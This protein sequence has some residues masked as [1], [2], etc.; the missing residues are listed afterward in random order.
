MRDFSLARG[1]RAASLASTLLLAGAAAQD[2]PKPAPSP[3]AGLD[4]TEPFF[5]GATYDQ[6]VPTPSSV[7][8]FDVGSKPATP[9]QIEAVLKAL[10][11]R[12]PRCR[13]FAYG[14]THEGR[15]LYYLVIASEANIRRLDALKAD[16]AK[17]ADPR[18]VTRAEGDHLA[19][20]LPALAWMAYVIHGDEMSSSDAALAVAHH[21]AAGTGADVKALLDNVVIAI[22]P[23]MNPDGRDRFLA[24][25][26]QNR[27]AQPGVDDQTLLHTGFWPD[28]RANHYLFDLNRDWVFVTQPESRGRVRA[29]GEWN[30]HFLIEGHEMGAQS[31]FFFNPPREAL[32]PQF[33][34][35]EQKWEARFGAD[36]AAAFDA[37][38]WRYFNGEN[39]DNW[40]PGFT[41]SWAPLR[42]AIG[43]LY[44]QA[45]IA[46]DAVRHANTQLE[47]YRES[48]HH[49]LVSTMANL[50]FLAQHRPE[51]LADFV[52]EKR[53]VVGPDATFPARTWALLPTPNAARLRRLLDLFEVQGIEVRTA[54]KSFRAAGRDRLGRAVADREFPAGTLLVA[55]RQPLGRLV[56]AAL[57]FDP[58]MTT[59]FLTEE[60][61]E[62]LRSNP[63]RVYDTTG[64][65][66]PMLYDVEAFELAGD[67]PGKLLAPAPAP[68]PLTNA[69][70]PVA[71]ILDG[72]DDASVIAAGRLMER[73]V[74]VR[75]ADRPAQFDGRDFPRGSVVVARKDNPSFAGDL[76]ATVREVCAELQ[77]TAA[78]VRSGNGPGESFDLGG[79]HF[80]L[81]QPPRIALVGREPIRS[82]GYGEVWHLV[83]HV[84]G[85]RA[86]YVDFRT[87]RSADLRRYNVLVIP[88]GAATALADRLDSLKAWVQGGGTL[89][90]IG[91]SA[92][93]LAKDQ[94]GLGRTRQLSDVLARFDDYRQAIVREWEARH[95]T[96]D[97]EKIWSFSPPA[98]VVYPWLI[99]EAGD[100]ASEDE[101][102]R[103]DAWRGLFM[104]IG[105]LLAA[106][107][108]DQ[109]WLT[110]GCG[111]YLPLIYSGRTVLHAPPGVQA[112]VR[113]G[114]FTPAPEAPKKP[115]LA[116]DKKAPAKKPAPGWTIAPP[117]YEMR[118]RMSGLVWPEA[119]DRLANSAA[120]TRE[121]IGAGQLIL[122]A[123]DP[124]FRAAA[125]GTTRVLANAL[126]CGPGMGASQP[127]NP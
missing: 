121:S 97:P 64:W 73:G 94:G 4:Y 67:F 102:K 89:I 13:L 87:L 20:T 113:L 69:D 33:P 68:A 29:I 41:S 96:P 52:A 123:A 49:Q 22:D 118:L 34:P 120:V 85:L 59:E 90:A 28:G 126:V 40:Y 31:T 44:E 100:K 98:E 23:L 18:R 35:T 62:I 32:N 11:A 50:T 25:M 51:I 78:G 117:G 122:F 63:S 127:I 124:A 46:T 61:R 57:E 3:L 95:T 10:A 74:W 6:N 16:Y 56:A 81:L 83:D 107:V 76:A 86:S 109:S 39:Y 26:A 105:A 115:E 53:Q 37:R 43:N 114:Y 65:S 111:D 112:P 101:L 92:G 24:M 21:L 70:T 14:H 82:V 79:R 17:L 42:G 119:A 5:P 1:L 55:S 38:G 104:P 7:L 72:A 2:L 58:H 106:R 36:Q 60:R 75:V 88:D 84:L 47:S 27:T 77:L 99:G 108:D 30:P 66:L 12:S 54:E 80:I 8:G 45:S 91:S 93:A 71:F 110:A 116:D 15:T 19:A 48:V 125:L 9:A 103:R